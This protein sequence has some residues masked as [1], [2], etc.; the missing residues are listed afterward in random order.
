M[1]GRELSLRSG[2]LTLL[3]YDFTTE[4][5]KAFVHPMHTSEGIPLTCLEPWDH[6]WHRGV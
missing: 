5:R 6:T 3:R 4:R 2:E 1:P